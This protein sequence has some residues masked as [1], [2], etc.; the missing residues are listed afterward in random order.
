MA[1]PPAQTA[2]QPVATAAGFA[3]GPELQNASQ[4]AI[5]ASAAEIVVLM[6]R[7]RPMLAAEGPTQNQ[8]AVEWTA[9]FALSPVAAKQ[10]AKGLTD[11]VT[12]WEKQS[13]VQFK[14]E[15]AQIQEITIKK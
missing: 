1:Q 13:G 8:M 12:R 14:L 6:G 9:G 4:F 11:T 3:P 7:A 15:D 2:P 5:M 10:L